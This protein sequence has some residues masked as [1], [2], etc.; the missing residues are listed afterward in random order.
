[1][2][3][4]LKKSMHSLTIQFIFL[5]IILI[6]IPF[7]LYIIFSLKIFSK[8]TLT[9][10]KQYLLQNLSAA[11]QLTHTSYNLIRDL[12]F[13]LYQNGTVLTLENGSISERN[14]SSVCKSL[15]ELL[16]KNEYITSIY[17]QTPQ[18]DYHT[19]LI[20]H[21][22]IDYAFTQKDSIL[23]QN[24]HLV[25][26]PKT[27]YR[28]SPSNTY[29]SVVARAL[30]GTKRQLIGIAYF[31]IDLNLF[32]S[33]LISINAENTI[34]YLL[35]SNSNILCDS[36]KKF[37]N[38]KFMDT[39]SSF[40]KKSGSLIQ[41][42]DGSSVLLV[43]SNSYKTGW[44]LVTV[45]PI[46]SILSGFSPVKIGLLLIGFAYLVLIIFLIALLNKKIIRPILYL[47]Y[48]M[49]VF[50]KNSTPTQ[51]I[52]K[53]GIKEID[54]LFSHFNAMTQQVNTLM[55]ER[56]KTAQEKMQ[57]ELKL[58]ASSLNPH[59]L[60][61]TL[62]TIKWL[63][64]INKQPTIQNITESLIFILMK[65]TN[66]KLVYHSIT[67]EIQLVKKYVQIQQIR[68]ANFTVKYNIAQETEKIMVRKFLLNPIIENAIIHGFGRGKLKDR[69]IKITTFLNDEA[70]HII[71]ED[72]GSGFDANIWRN[73]SFTPDLEHTHIGLK[74][75]E[76]L[77]QM[78]GENADFLV[79][80]IPNSGTKIR[81]ILPINKKEMRT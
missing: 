59:F 81:F 53:S 30:Y 41:K 72:N 45:T 24:G 29:Y 77:V 40:E 35:D 76:Q 58:I 60:Y 66:Q 39:K 21:E 68:F 15:E 75:I 50:G 61:N 20:D 38:Q 4:R 3:E 5:F 43:Y 37:F 62:Y 78:E 65:I 2:I 18:Q 25:W 67:E 52:C 63:A 46:S 31:T 19:E 54:G 44:T 69:F 22:L 12:S 32:E 10:Y 64:V 33:A 74:N 47:Q 13:E 28:Q 27:I 48:E 26:F 34:T 23:A 71:I 7:F 49:D 8:N 14:I 17:I 42:L 1:M 55:E 36:E 16:D 51:L 73:H 6:I 11:Q 70:V 57:L 9:I 56:S 79:E 80:S